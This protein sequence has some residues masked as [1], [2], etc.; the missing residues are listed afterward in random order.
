MSLL[1]VPAI[2]TAA[3]STF[4][5]GTPHTGA[6]V[7]TH[8]IGARSHPLNRVDAHS[9]RSAPKISWPGAAER[10]VTVPKAGAATPASAA[11]TPVTVGASHRTPKTAAARVAKVKVRVLGNAESTA[12]LGT[13]GV[14]IATS[15]AD[16]VADNGTVWVSLNYSGFAGAYGSDY[17]S[18]LHLVRL[19]QCAL[20]TPQKSSCRTATAIPTINNAQR[21]TLGADVSVAGTPTVLAAVAA[22]SGDTGDYSATPL[23]SSSSW[24]VSNQTGDFSWSYPLVL[25]P[26]VGGAAPQLALSYDS[27]S[28]DGRTS[29]T[30]NQA[31]WVGDGWELWS[32]YIQRSY[33]AC[34]DDQND[35]ANNVGKTTGDQCWGPDNAALSLEGHSSQ[36]VKD[37]DSGDW[38]LKNDDGT[39][40]EKLTGADN[41]AHN[42]EYWR[43][44]TPDGTQYFFGRNKLP[45]WETGDATSDS[46]WTLPVY[47]NDPDDPCHQAAYADSWC[48][49]AWRWNL[50]YVV[51]PHGNAIS[52]RYDKETGY[53]GRG[54]DADARTDYTRGGTLH[55]IDYGFSDGHA[56]DS[57]PQRVSFVVANRC[58]A[59]STCDTSHPASWPDTPWDQACLSAPCT[60][61]T[62][63]IFF[64][65]KQLTTITTQVLKNGSY[66]NVNQ[67]TLGHEF[68]SPGDNDA[69]PLWLK[70]ITRTGLNG[71]TKAMP[72]VTFDGTQLHNRVDTNTDGLS[73][74]TRYRISSI[75]TES[76]GQTRIAYSDPECVEGSKMPSAPDSNTLR[77]MPA[78]WSPPGESQKL[79]W[80]HKY[81]VTE[82]D[83]VDLTDD[84]SV[85]EVTH[86]DYTSKPSWHYDN[87]PLLRAKYRTWSE[88]HGYQTVTVRH[89]NVGK[90][91]SATDYVYMTGMDGDRQSDGTTR[92][93]KVTDSQGGALTD[94]PQYQGFQREQIAYNGLGGKVLADTISDPWTHGPTATNGD[95][96]SSW[97][98]APGGSTTRSQLADGTW[99]TTKISTSYN[100]DALP[101]LVDDQ[102]DIATAADDK[103][104]RTTYTTRNTTDWIL[105]H[106]A[107]TEV[108]ATR[109]S[110]T[111]TPDQVLSHT[112]VYYDNSTTLGAAVKV[113]DITKSEAITSFTGDT[114]IYTTATTATFDSYGRTL[115]STDALNHTSST[116]FTPTTG[117][118]VTGTTTTDAIGN[119]T[120]ITVDPA[121]GSNTSIVDVN[122]RRTTLAYD[123]LGELTSVWLP[124]TDTG[125]DPNI[126]YTY[127]IRN[128]APTV[129]TTQRLVYGGT[130]TIPVALRYSTSYAFYDGLL[131]P[132][133]T[134]TPAP[135]GG[136]E[137]TDTRYD[138]R[139][140]VAITNDAYHDEQDP[141]TTLYGPTGV[142]ADLSTTTYAYDGAERQTAAIY[143]V[144]GTE[145]WRTTTAYPGADQTNVTPPAG[146]TPT[147]TITDAR[148]RT[149]QFR[150]YQAT[151]PAGAYDTTS[152]TYTP[153]DQI[154]TV[155]DP[156]GNTWRYTYDIRGFKTKS[157]DPDTG[158]TTS[159]YDNGG[160]LTS[161]TD[162]RNITLAY[163]YDKIGR[164]TGEYLGDTNGLQLAGWAYDT[165]PGGKGLP[166]SSTR[167][168]GS[169]AYTESVDGYDATGR[170]T[171]STVTIPTSQGALAGSYDTTTTYNPDGA[172][173]TTTLPAAGGM[174]AETLRYSHDPLGA[175]TQMYST[176]GGN[177]VYGMTYGADG[178]LVQRFLGKYGSRVE[179]DYSYE[180]GT[181]RLTETK[182]LTEK[183]G[184]TPVSQAQYGYDPAGNVTS[185]TDT[186]DQNDRQCFQYDYLDRLTDAWTPHPTGTDSS[187]PGSCATL[188]STTS[189]LGGPAPYWHTY[190]YDKTGNRTSL[191]QH[192]AGQDT[193]TTSTYPAPGSTQPHALQSTT[194]TSSIGPGSTA[195][196]Q[197][198]YTYD[199]AGN[200]KTR[201]I[202][203]DTQTLDWNAD[204]ALATFAKGDNTSSYTYDADGTELIRHDP[205]GSATLYL[206]NGME[207]HAD[208]GASTSTA[209]RYYSHLGDT[210][211]VRT[212]AGVTWLVGDHHGTDTLAV[213][214]ATLTVTRRRVDPFGQ[215]RS[216]LPS[217]V[218]DRG[219]VG[220]TQDANTGLTNLGAREYDPTLGRF[221]SADPLADLTQPQQ[222]NGYSYANNNPTTQ[223]DPS[224]QMP[225]PIGRNE[226]GG[227]CDSTCQS[228]A[229]TASPDP[230]IE[231][232]GANGTVLA[233]NPNGTYSINGLSV[234]GYTG[235]PRKLAVALDE[236][237]GI[238]AK[239]HGTKL[240]EAGLITLVKQACTE[241]G[242]SS[243][244]GPELTTKLATRFRALTAA[245]HNGYLPEYGALF[246]LAITTGPGQ[247][248]AGL[249]GQ[250]LEG[251]VGHESSSRSSG[252]HVGEGKK[253]HEDEESTPS[254][255]SCRSTHSF[256]GETPVVLADG[257][258]KRID[259]VKIGDRIRNAKPDSR[260]SQ[261]HTVEGITVTTTDSAFVDVYLAAGAGVV[262][263]TATTH[264]RIWDKTAHRW[265]EAGL[266][267]VG[268]YVQAGGGRS[269]RIAS[270][271]KYTTE[272]TTY[273]LTVDGLHT[274]FVLAGKIPVLVH[275][276]AGSIGCGAGGAPIY[277]IPAGS[278]G[279]AGAGKR[280]PRGELKAAGIGKNAPPGS[281]AP[282]C[283][284]CRT[285]PAT[286]IDHVE[287]R[288]KGGDLSDENL[289]PACTFCN[290]SK[291][292]R[293]RPLNPPP[294][295]TGSWPPPW[296]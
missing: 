117:G 148:G 31:S 242:V 256:P 202:G 71:G 119:A 157:E 18:R 257:K 41:G 36:I 66:S 110:A 122:G 104:T 128:D 182:V 46:T 212:A 282:L 73:A 62:T 79:G 26:S 226:G 8:A 266:L 197:N 89:G 81:V 221:L 291:R 249:E 176:N 241:K 158:T 269:A 281:T 59:G 283:S 80:F 206:P 133:Q 265:K 171:G 85:P 35:G 210:I 33:K 244:C 220:G 253:S 146:S 190:G 207:L 51:D 294:N 93:V 139:G 32:G 238:W 2:A 16:G 165:L 145:K 111:A 167:Y 147:S 72:A 161:V 138:D 105:N 112:R 276:I 39:R 11:G 118:P 160:E 191:T 184:A 84:T 102:G 246:D 215:T 23:S 259:Q 132:R 19:P 28:L 88:W 55:E 225:A 7:P 187:T 237:W 78:Y 37:A 94:S 278:S 143:Q 205:D 155:T 103:C 260:S 15:R 115:T 129:V 83:N 43:V 231:Y 224:G 228:G 56:Y 58:S 272:Q 65:Q 75:T 267:K 189:D 21:S 99:R 124:G 172:V 67:W 50:D 200:T 234:E 76:G 193:I 47:G 222:L 136:R 270:V 149:T 284:Y 9:V 48:Q 232:H 141:S 178:S 61:K 277:D 185:I 166:V 140:L 154:H 264:H 173:A 223:S 4:T 255:G 174:K 280:I 57:A 86:Y 175:V 229:P 77:C 290:S 181:H 247:D 195:T 24:Q 218:G 240:S 219:F 258:S 44:T 194:T 116:S 14:V 5:P 106:L 261:S 153:A 45:G 273:D 53:Y 204:G 211:A 245:T 248:G 40:I 262:V 3:P 120:T 252:T 90:T 279:G 254:G 54:G 1:S 271:R 101:T 213:D 286:S 198:T 60:G 100:N 38:K 91:Q 227:F 287:P 217:W 10:T 288:S 30:N 114:P 233:K 17:G 126:K 203:G 96:V 123:P 230:T 121:T 263:L 49:Q 274:Y 296:W 82:V 127:T 156:A 201:T 275:N 107:E 216:G 144:A 188:P 209:T 64:T 34:Q 135:S 293:I 25:P 169:D 109:C 87:N 251:G 208:S 130:D 68:L 243:G 113:G 74:L 63:P 29:A 152:Y 196:E 52:Y 192:L 179:E 289:T 151:S 250:N 183:T 95:G 292:D 186:A 42:G 125:S 162:A 150:Q 180:D 134:Q 236:K 163:S 108:D 12:T 214:G 168:D 6:V 22:A 131:R 137:I 97:M 13:S 142:P 27:Q 69:D 268:H 295:Y 199:A 285:N 177:Y 159:T 164:K 235:D 239:S 98:L 70:S 92:T 20:T 170:P